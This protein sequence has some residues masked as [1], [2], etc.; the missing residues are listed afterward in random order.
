MRTL[1]QNSFAAVLIGSLTALTACGTA[2]PPPS[3]SAESSPAASSGAIRLTETFTSNLHGYLV[4]YP[5]GWST[6]PATEAWAVGAAGNGWGSPVLDDL[7][8]STVRLTAASQ[9]LAAGQT[10]DAWLG[11]YA[12]NGACEGSD[13]AKWPTVKVGDQVGVMS[14]DGCNALAG[15]IASGGLLFDV[16]VFVGQRAYNFTVDG[17]TDHAFV[18]AILATVIFN[19]A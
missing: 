12:S 9:P 3:P 7:H 8:G 18:E 17:A 14:A 11:G 16:V 4:K 10:S 2:S 1:A 19:P 5:A 15:T 13:P 6:V